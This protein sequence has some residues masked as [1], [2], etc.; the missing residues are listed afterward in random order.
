M[1]NPPQIKKEC[2]AWILLLEA[3]PATD[4]TTQSWRLMS[5]YVS[6]SLSW[7][8]AL[9]QKLTLKTG[10]MTALIWMIWATR[11]KTIKLSLQVFL[12]VA[13]WLSTTDPSSRLDQSDRKVLSLTSNRIIWR[14]LTCNYSKINKSGHPWL[15]CP[16]TELM[17]Q[18]ICLF[19][20][21]VCTGD[22]CRVL[23]S[24]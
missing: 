13:A 3:N 10:L 19:A 2:L 4:R 24:L 14:C 23:S 20:S 1:T 5:N 6:P 17:L 11:S 22:A 18:F 8:P 16:F 7:G 21:T 9:I 15:V 12:Q